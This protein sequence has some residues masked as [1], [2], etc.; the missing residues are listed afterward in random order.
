M[1]MRLVCRQLATAARDYFRVGA[2]GA[3][4]GLGFFRR[5]ESLF[6]DAHGT[7][8][9]NAYILRRAV[10]TPVV[11]AQNQCACAAREVCAR[12]LFAA[13]NDFGRLW[14]ICRNGGERVVRCFF[15]KVL[16]RWRET[17]LRSRVRAN[18][19]V[20][21]HHRS[22]NIA[23]SRPHQMDTQRSPVMHPSSRGPCRL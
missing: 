6:I 4:N 22:Q 15:E 17:G 21:I 9:T 18:V 11:H 16:S 23:Q 14:R 2:R 20:A 10:Q 1:G 7:S 19:S 12:P 3:G 13:P 5:G 8:A